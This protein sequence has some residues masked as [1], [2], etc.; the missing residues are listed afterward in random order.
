MLRRTVLFSALAA[1]AA[2]LARGRRVFLHQPRTGAIHPDPG[3]QLRR[4]QDQAGISLVLD[5]DTPD[6]LQKDEF[7]L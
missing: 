3:H 6:L 2:G 1:A 4:A 5:L 7:L